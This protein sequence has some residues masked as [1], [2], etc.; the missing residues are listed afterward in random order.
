MNGVIVYVIIIGFL[1]A[2]IIL[3]NV[4]HYKER[5]ELT[6]KIMCKDYAQYVSANNTPGKSGNF[7]REGLDKI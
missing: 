4:L 1:I 5:R 7:I 6:N 2:T 3:Q